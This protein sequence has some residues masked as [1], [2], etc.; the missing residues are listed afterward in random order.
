MTL[1]YVT[2]L[3][4]VDV[5]NDGSFAQKSDTPEYQRFEHVRENTSEAVLN[6]LGITCLN[7]DTHPFRVQH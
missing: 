1:K 5:K 6:S 4:D 2:R 7:P 3:N